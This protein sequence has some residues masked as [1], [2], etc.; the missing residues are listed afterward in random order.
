MALCDSVN[1]ICGKQVH[2]TKI[3]K[4][5]LIDKTKVTDNN[6]IIISALQAKR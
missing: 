3:V 1:D 4:I 6:E 5:K 2:K